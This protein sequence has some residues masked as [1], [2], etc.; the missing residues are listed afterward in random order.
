MLDTLRETFKFP[1]LQKRTVVAEVNSA[2]ASYF[3]KYRWCS[4]LATIKAMTPF[5]ATRHTP[6]RF[7]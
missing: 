7:V 2:A 1:S 5:E 3:L 6:G 4:A